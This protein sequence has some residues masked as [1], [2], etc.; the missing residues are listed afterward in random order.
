MDC[1]TTVNSF[2]R[3]VKKWNH[4]IAPFLFSL[5]SFF[6]SHFCLLL[7][8][9][10]ARRRPPLQL[11]RGRQQPFSS[12][13]S[14]LFFPLLEAPA[15]RKGAQTTIIG[16]DEQAMH[17]VTCFP[18]PPFPLSPLF[19]FFPPPL[20]VAP[21]GTGPNRDQL[22]HLFPLVSV[23]GACFTV[24]PCSLFFSSSP[25]PPPLFFQKK[26]FCFFLVKGFS[27]KGQHF[28]LPFF[29]PSSALFSARENEASLRV[30]SFFLCW[31]PV[32]EAWE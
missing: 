17:G 28:F 25:P 20:L 31:R 18:L 4:T 7:V 10:L 16:S 3:N 19:P 11:I 9:R 1:P 32:Q 22:G 14:P 26:I 5:L 6:F 2:L 27:Y 29:F 21:F 13:F 24:A 23:G 8:G 12:P 30:G 15:F